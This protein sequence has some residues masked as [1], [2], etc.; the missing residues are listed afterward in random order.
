M[1]PSLYS[2]DVR[3]CVALSYRTLASLAADYKLL[4]VPSLSTEV[5]NS[6]QFGPVADWQEYASPRF[7][8]GISR[9]DSQ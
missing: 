7:L 4:T 2:I 3:R 5:P 1:S 6:S 9:R 8:L